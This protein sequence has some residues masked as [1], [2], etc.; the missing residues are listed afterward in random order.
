MQ[1]T[2]PTLDEFITAGKPWPLL[3]LPL[4]DPVHWRKLKSCRLRQRQKRR[5]QVGRILKGMILTINALGEGRASSTELTSSDSSVA[6]D[7]CRMKVPWTDARTLAV[8]RLTKSASC[9][10]RARRSCCLT[11]V[12]SAMAQLLKAPLDDGYI[13]STGPKQI[14]MIADRMVEPTS[15]ESID[16]LA[17]LPDEDALY[18]SDEK[19]VVCKVGKCEDMFRSIE[20]H[21]GFVGGSLDEYMKYLARDDVQHL[22]RWDLMANIKA[23]AGVSTVLKKNGVDQRK[24]IMQCAA[25]YMFEDPT[26]RADLGM[27]G[28]SATRRVN[29]C[30]S[31]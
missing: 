12:H 26:K 20:E 22:W 3:P 10:A 29:G 15:Q 1:E 11:G 6:S 18:Y 4:P 19:H 7:G 8:Q 23:I 5:L 14:P 27:G 13:R 16:M 28:G 21:Y 17:V 9:V 24:L 2:L 31:L 25:N 30:G